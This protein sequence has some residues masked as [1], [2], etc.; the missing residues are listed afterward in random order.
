MLYDELMRFN[1]PEGFKKLQETKPIR[2]TETKTVFET[3]A[4]GAPVVEVLG[5]RPKAYQFQVDT[6]YEKKTLQSL[7]G[8]FYLTKILH[9]LRPGSVPDIRQSGETRDGEQV[10]DRDAYTRK[11]INKISTAGNVREEIRGI[12]LGNAL[13]H[14][15][16]NYNENGDGGISYLEEFEPWVIN[17]E[18]RTVEWNFD[19]DSL[20]A[21]IDALQDSEV[22]TTCRAFLDRL[23]MLYKE[24]QKGFSDSEI[25]RTKEA[26]ELT[27][28][29]ERIMDEFEETYNLEELHAIVGFRSTAERY[30]SVRH[31]ANIAL[32]P[33][34]EMLNS[35]EIKRSVTIDEQIRLKQRYN[36]L[37]K[38]VGSITIDTTGAWFDLIDHNR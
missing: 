5:P 26:Q 4:H 35:P 13:V 21:A 2:K 19:R 23:E 9:L 17:P 22:Q 11:K 28:R 33:I 14:K 1:S 34:S 32:T 10:I 6:S 24:A 38:A 12:G 7:K 36:V 25:A 27:E 16:E 15:P 18:T 31:H 29:L 8:T 20:I 30:S 3:D 37:S